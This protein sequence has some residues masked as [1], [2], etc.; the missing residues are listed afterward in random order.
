[1]VVSTERNGIIDLSDD[2][3]SGSVD[4]RENAS[5]SF[6][7]VI[8]NQY[9]K[10][11]N[12]FTP[13]DRIV[14]QMK[15]LTWLQI[16]CGYLDSVPLFSI[17]PKPI[18]LSGQCTLKVLKNWPW[19]AHT[20]A[21][22][23][24]I[25]GAL[26]GTQQDGG[27][28]AIAVKLLTDVAAWPKE[29]IHF[30]RVPQE[31]IDK[32]ELVYDQ[33]NIQQSFLDSLLGTNPILAG[34]PVS[35]STPDL[36]AAP[37]V[38]GV[39]STTDMHW[40]T[41]DIDVILATIRQTESG[42]NYGAVNRG[43][44]KGDIA[45]GAYQI[46]TSTWAN[47][48]GVRDAYQATPA[49]QDAKATE[50]VTYIRTR[51]GDQ[52]VNIPYGWYY[53]KVFS[54]PTLLDQIPAQN[55]GNKLTIR[56]YGVKWLGN[57]ATMYKKMRGIDPP[58][59]SSSP[60]FN[61]T[62]DNGKQ[63]DTPTGQ[64]GTTPTAGGGLALY[65]IPPGTDRLNYS[66]VGWRP[67]GN[68][69]VP[70][71]AMSYAKTTGYGHPSAIAALVLL[72][73]AATDAGLDMSGFCYRSYEQ[74]AAGYAQSSLFAKP[75]T[76]IHGWGLAC[77]FTVLTGGSKKYAGKSLTSMYDTPEYKWMF[78]NSWKWGW[79]HPIWAQ[80]GQSKPEPW[81]WEFLAFENF[82]NDSAAKP[83]QVDNSPGNTT[84]PFNDTSTGL[85]PFPGIDNKA[86]FS[87]LAFWQGNYENEVT[88]DSEYLAGYKALM[89]DTP[90]MQTLADLV[91][92]VGRNYCS[93]PNGDFIAWWPDYWGEYGIAGAMDVELIELQ[94]F[95]IEW[96]DAALITHEYV[97]GSTGL[98]SLGPLPTWV[99]DTTS[100]YQ[101][102]GVATVE[103][104]RFLD[105]VININSQM[106]PF[107]KDPQ[108]LLTRF[109]A[110]IDRQQIGT[111][112]GPQ[113]EFY[114]AVK[115][116]M[117]SW[118]A[119]FTAQIPMTFMPELFP[120][121]LLRIP[122]LS[123]QFYVKEV[124]HTFDLSD[125]GGFH[126]SATVMAPSAMDGSGFGILPKAGV[127]PVQIPA[128]GHFH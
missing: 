86:L 16:M 25:H 40:A 124:N 45:S 42:N 91:G 20:V 73:Q 11:D 87:A 85:N 118:A 5:H 32:F 49:V 8:N 54:D 65:P 71:S 122:E 61:V 31:W 116:F 51:Y 99:G 48:G 95:S 119:M 100:A 37:G 105:A 21:A 57:Y 34:E 101:T 58:S 26:D 78:Q 22:F 53:P 12:V 96:N 46:V 97:E 127:P 14:V 18:Q 74:Q 38:P 1:M 72:Q 23:N 107:M 24:L 52:V 92:V 10:Y 94:D 77:D 36:S 19:D 80:Q 128:G 2:I 102:H 64:L 112:Y 106:Y 4:L 84:N 68:G 55:E 69:H 3:A 7:F 93:A 27:M 111:I 47:Y 66:T 13:N 29:R 75:G 98:A 28:S 123:I 114:Y 104:P 126:T 50:M 17:Y 125:G 103:I 70:L 79:G 6:S 110:R 76:S 121:M 90:V 35:T 63:T 120:G 60:S 82:R 33:V 39:N 81:H 15:R 30:G 9:R 117:Q 89:N 44:G 109:G 67:E 43:D 88:A 59:S 115:L 83:M 41:A 108:A 113:Q 62:F 56:Q